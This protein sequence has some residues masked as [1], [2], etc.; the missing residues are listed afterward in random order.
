MSRYRYEYYPLIFHI[1]NYVQQCISSTGIS[2]E[3]MEVAFESNISDNELDNADLFGVL[4]YSSDA[5]TNITFSMQVLITPNSIS[6][7]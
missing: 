6:T 1:T 2:S 3:T 7:K 4:P 5:L